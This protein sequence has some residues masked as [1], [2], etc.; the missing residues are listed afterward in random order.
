[1]T[2]ATLA[3]RFWAK[4][5]VTD[6]CWVWTGARTSEGYGT[7]KVDG[8]TQGA[9]RFSW[10]L[11]HGPIATGLFVCHR[12]DNRRCVNPE[13]LFLGTQA[14]NIADMITKGRKALL[15]GVD[16]YHGAK[17]HCAHGHPFDEENTHWYSKARGGKGRQCRTCNRLRARV[18][19]SLLL[20]SEGSS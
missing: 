12:C 7:I 16:N 9:H 15:S 6:D 14:E 18:R 20:D 8:K 17:T 5:D 13:H 2:A 3:D 10:V 11:H 19:R 1:M 4:V